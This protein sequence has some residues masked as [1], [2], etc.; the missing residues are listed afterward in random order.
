[1]TLR[2]IFF[3]FAFLGML[4]NAST[5]LKAQDNSPATSI[6]EWEAVKDL[7]LQN[8]P[9]ARKAALLSPK[10]EQTILKAKG[11]FDPMLFTDFDQKEFDG[12]SYFRNLDAGVKIP[13]RYAVQFKAG[14]ETNQGIYVNNENTVPRAGLMYAGL[15]MPL[16]QGL[17]IDERRTMLR[18]ADIFASMTAVERRKILNDLQMDAAD[19]Y[20]KWTATGNEL[21]IYETAIALAAQRL[22]AVRISFEQGDKPAIDTLEA[23][24]QLQN[25]VVSFNKSLI[26]YQKATLELSNFLWSDDGSPLLVQPTVLPPSLATIAIQRQIVADTVQNRLNNLSSVHPDLLLYDLKLQDLQVE[27]R[28]KAEKLKPKL[29]IKYNF[30]LEPSNSETASEVSL[31]N[32]KWGFSFKMPLLFREARGD[33]Q[34]NRIKQQETMLDRQQKTL[35]IQNKIQYYDYQIQNIQS[36]IFIAENNISNYQQLLDAERVKFSIGESTLFLVNSRENKLIDAQLKLVDFQY[37]YQAAQAALL[38]AMGG[39]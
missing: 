9:M 37:K 35:E 2:H 8:H 38:W 30:L 17:L 27:Q 33:L 23:L 36:Q 18:R 4:L 20:W 16:V 24:I 22:D 6:L 7:V 19:A 29:N 14:Y 21:Q 10:A 25:R 5:T 26:K 12:K 32:Y 34:L 11:G 39:L 31:N 3:F 1:M 13:T 28:W 15:E